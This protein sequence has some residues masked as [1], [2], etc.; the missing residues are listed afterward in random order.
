MDVIVVGAAFPHI[1][2]R[3]LFTG[4][5]LFSTSVFALWRESEEEGDCSDS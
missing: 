5:P 3:Q 2:D 4:K 1:F